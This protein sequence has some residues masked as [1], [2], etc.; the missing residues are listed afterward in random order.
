MRIKID[1]SRFLFSFPEKRYVEKAPSVSNTILSTI[2]STILSTGSVPL[3]KNVVY[4]RC[5]Q[6][7]TYSAAQR[8]DDGKR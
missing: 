3:L 6:T 5:G 7:E 8:P 1:K 4:C 2:S